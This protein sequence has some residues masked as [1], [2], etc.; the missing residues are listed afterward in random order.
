MASEIEK[1]VGALNEICI[2]ELN[3]KYKFVFGVVHINNVNQTTFEVMR[4]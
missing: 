1:Q 3:V 4:V 2:D